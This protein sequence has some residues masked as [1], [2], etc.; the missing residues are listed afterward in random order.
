MCLNVAKYLFAVVFAF[1]DNVKY[2]AFAS[3]EAFCV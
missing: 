2:D 3:S 1:A